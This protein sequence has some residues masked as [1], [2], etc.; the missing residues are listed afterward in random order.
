VFLGPVATLAENRLELERRIADFRRHR[1]SDPPY[2]LVPGRGSLMRSDLPDAAEPMLAC[3][4]LVLARIGP[5]APLRY[6]GA[7]D[8]AELIGWEAEEYRRR[9][10]RAGL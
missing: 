5:D 10:R 2:V 3:L 4:G 8:E 9:I 7:G 6:L 1:A